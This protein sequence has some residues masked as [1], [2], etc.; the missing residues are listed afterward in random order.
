MKMVVYTARFGD[1]D[2]LRPPAEVDPRVRYLCFGD[3]PC[4]VKPYEWIRLPKASDARLAA[5]RIKV[6]ADHPLLAAAHLTIWHDASYAWK[7][8]PRR[9]VQDVIPRTAEVFALHHPRRYRIEDEAIA[10]A[11]YGYLPLP[12]AEAYVAEYRVAGFQDQVLT[13]S[14][15]LGRR[16]SART[17]AFNASWWT[18]VLRWQ[19][20]DQASI[21]FAAWTTG[22]AIAHVR[23]TIRDNPYADWRDAVPA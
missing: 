4:D 8:S 21:D 2:D 17:A 10:I 14:G 6:L 15:L 16:A 11:R 7:V 9:L 13:A 5:R 1:T 18:E 23:G 20:R 22:I 12:I 19:G 3:Q